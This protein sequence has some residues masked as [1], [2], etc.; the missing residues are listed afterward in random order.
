[1]TFF[2]HNFELSEQLGMFCIL[3]GLVTLVSCLMNIELLRALSS[4]I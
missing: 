1:M 2:G 4:P 3:S